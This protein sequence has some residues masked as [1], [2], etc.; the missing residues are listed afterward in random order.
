MSD[1]VDRL[2][3]ELERGG[4]NGLLRFALGKVHIDA[5]DFETA[6]S[7]LQRAVELLPEYSAA[8]ALLGRS[9]AHLGNLSNALA[10]WGQGSIVAKSNGH[11][12]AQR[13]ME[14]WMR[15]ATRQALHK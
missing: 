5:G 7:H 4:D 13:Q 10:T 8:W 9:Q 2:T 1:L 14:V 12:Q 6:T 3:N 15:K 11:V